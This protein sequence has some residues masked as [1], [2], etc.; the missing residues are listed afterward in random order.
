MLDHCRCQL[1]PN[2]GRSQLSVIYHHVVTRRAFDEA[3]I[4][5]AVGGG[6]ACR[7]LWLILVVF[8]G[9]TVWSVDSN[10]AGLML[11]T[12][13]LLSPI[14]L[15]LG[16]KLSKHSAGFTVALFALSWSATFAAWAFFGFW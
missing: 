15:M 1:S 10:V 14:A 2:C 5:A 16:L 11:Q 7:A 6:W 9:F 8:S 12:G 3:F 13:L 4:M